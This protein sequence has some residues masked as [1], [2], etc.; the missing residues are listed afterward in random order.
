MVPLVLGTPP[1]PKLH[2]GLGTRCGVGVRVWDR[3]LGLEHVDFTCDRLGP[4]LH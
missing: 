4:W 2:I 1:K 3:V